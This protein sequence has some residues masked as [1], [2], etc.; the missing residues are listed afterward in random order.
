MKNNKSTNHDMNNHPP[1]YMKKKKLE[2]EKIEHTS[3]FI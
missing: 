2:K 3:I 1:H